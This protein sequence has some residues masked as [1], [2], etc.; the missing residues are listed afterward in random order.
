MGLEEANRNQ[1]LTNERKKRGFLFLFLFHVC[2]QRIRTYIIVGLSLLHMNNI[3]AQIKITYFSQN[4][5]CIL[6]VPLLKKFA[7]VYCTFILILHDTVFL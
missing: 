2:L 7:I 1:F 4:P 3:H 6:K 5:V